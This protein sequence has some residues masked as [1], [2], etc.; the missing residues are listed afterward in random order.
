MESK[1]C[2]KCDQS[3]KISKFSLLK[4]GKRHGWCKEC[5]S[6][7]TRKYYKKNKEQYLKK[8]R[9]TNKRYRQSNSGK[10]S[11][12][13]YQKKK[14]RINI[15]YRLRILLGT[16]LINTLKRKSV[17][18]TSSV[19][20]LLGCSML[21]FKI[22]LEDRFKPGMD[23]SNQGRNGWEI[24]HVKPVTKFD[25]TKESEQRECFHYTNLQ[26]LWRVDNL[27]KSNKYEN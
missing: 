24:D 2:P 21:E 17:T 22:Y 6:A 10:E 1:Y 16:G 27:T 8:K 18:K 5:A 26:P 7:A 12:Y 20:K 11:Q 19:L 25:L 3:K 14:Y 9:I 23:W 13:K 4:S 15:N